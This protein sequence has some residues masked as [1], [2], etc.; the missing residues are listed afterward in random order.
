M[1][2]NMMKQ[3][4]SRQKSSAKKRGIDWQFTY[5]TWLEFWGDD[6]YRRGVGHDKLCMQRFGDVGPYHPDNCKKGYAKENAKTAG[7]IRKS[8][9]TLKHTDF[10]KTD[11][12]WAIVHSA[13]FPDGDK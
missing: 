6:I 8:K 1:T 3:A 12:E 4:Y 10:N 9:N 11:E 2:D 7:V 13:F 5:E